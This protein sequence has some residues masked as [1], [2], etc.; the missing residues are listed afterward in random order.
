VNIQLTD[1]QMTEVKFVYRSAGGNEVPP[2]V[3]PILPS[4]STDRP[5]LISIE[6]EPGSLRA[7]LV[8]TGKTGEAEVS[9]SLTP[10]ATPVAQATIVIVAGEPVTSALEFSAPV[11]RLPKPP[12]S[13]V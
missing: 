9:L 4:W 10:G 12:G 1:S 7:K 2:P 3:G 13:F 5:D 8:T 11:S 6:T